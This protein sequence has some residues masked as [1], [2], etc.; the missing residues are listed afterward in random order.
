MAK[1]IHNWLLERNYKYIYILQYL[2]SI[3]KYCLGLKSVFLSQKNRSANLYQCDARF[4]AL[5]KIMK[6]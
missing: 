2:F 6:N 5:I 1:P 3:E 4:Q